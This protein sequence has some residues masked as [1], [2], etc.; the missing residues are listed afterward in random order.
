[1]QQSAL[2]DQWRDRIDQ[3]LDSQLALNQPANNASLTEAMHYAVF[4]GGK[5]IRPLL[6]YASGYWQ[7]IQPQFLDA[8]ATAI[9]LVHCYSL[10]HDDLPAMDN[11]DLRRGK[12]TCHKA[13]DEA[14]AILV[15]DAL[16]SLAFELVLSDRRL[17][18]TIK[19]SMALTLARAIGRYG[20]AAGQALDLAAVHS[21]LDRQ[22][23][24]ALHSR[25]TGALIACAL[26]IGGL[27]A[28]AGSEQLERLTT[29]GYTLG[30]AF[31]VQDDILD[32]ESTT[33]VLGKQQGADV[34]AGKTT[35]PELLGLDEAKR[36][37]DNLFNKV[38]SMLD[39]SP[40]SGPITELVTW[41]AQR[42]H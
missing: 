13:F 19:N 3:Q 10:V 17:N 30:L 23:L 4:N 12:L 21:S 14:T 32:L 8:A 16:Q 36:Y 15:G 18:S 33:E 20:M 25:K 27:A 2:L 35:Y 29:L 39:E 7:G 42:D 31:Q 40:A 9:E 6:V 38:S 5:R 37:R 26:H 24:E 1:M 34:T 41:I 11:D 28:E 22:Q